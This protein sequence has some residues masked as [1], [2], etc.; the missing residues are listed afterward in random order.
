[1]NSVRIHPRLR[2]W[3]S[4]LSSLL[5]LFQRSPIIQLI[6]PEAKILG[7]SAVLDTATFAIAT[8]VGLGAFDSVAGATNSVV[9]NLPLGPTYTNVPAA[10]NTQLNF[11]Y[12]LLKTPQNWPKAYVF[13]AGS[14]ALPTGLAKDLDTTVSVGTQTIYGKPSQMGG[15]FGPYN[16][17]SWE[18][19]T[20][21]GSYWYTGTFYIYVLGF[22][23]QPTATPSTIVSGNGSSLSCAITGATPTAT[24][25][26]QWYVGTT[27]GTGT[28]I[29]G[30][31]SSTYNIPSLTTTTSYWVKVRSLL[32]PSDFS[33]DS[34]AVTVNVGPPL[35]AAAIA[36]QP[37]S[38]T[39]SSGGYANLSVAASGTAP[40]TYQWYEGTSPT[41]T[42]LITGATSSTYTTPALSSTTSYWVKVT[43]AGNL[44]GVNSNTATVTVNTP[45]LITTQPA[46]KAI[47]SGSTTTLTVAA[48]GTSPSFA[49]YQGTVGDYSNLVGTGTSFPTPALT[50]TTSYWVRAYNDA[51]SVNSNTATVTVTSVSVAVSPASVLENSG[52]ALVYTFTRSG[53]TTGTLTANYTVSGTATQGTDYPSTSGTVAFTDG[54][55]TASVSITP[56]GDTIVEP[57]ETVILTVAAGTGYTIGT[58]NSATG[59]ITNDDTSISVAVSPASVLENSGSALVYTFTRTGVTTGTLTANYTVSGTAT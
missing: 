28:S 55:A 8:V 40:L 6:F 5:L 9:Q 26:Y 43:N 15:P 44:A 25:T 33:I 37:A 18:N 54:S 21:R 59:T 46:S 34:N 36:T 53:V 42:N 49:W 3:S 10:M 23:T 11:V 58:P 30:A 57:D 1:M 19:T 50:S 56:T 27:P 13:A 12:K 35:V 52:S 51:G 24:I 31:N 7:G 41:T 47:N 4:R 32:S 48:S 14:V 17:E 45:P 38:T 2:L 16:I 22:S 20:S 29:T 39:I